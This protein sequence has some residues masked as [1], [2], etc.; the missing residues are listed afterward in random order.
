[1]PFLHKTLVYL[2]HISYPLYLF[3]F[4]I[5]VWAR[6]NLSMEY[7]QWVFAFTVSIFT[8]SAIHVL[9]EKP[10]L[11]YLKAH[12]QPINTTPAQQIK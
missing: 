12:P 7:Q 11:N 1:L 6:Q 2:G 10:L 4:P 5:I 8:A 3:H 9:I